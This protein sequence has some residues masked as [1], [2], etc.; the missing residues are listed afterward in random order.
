MFRAIARISRH[1]EAAAGEFIILTDQLHCWPVDPQKIPLIEAE[2]SYCIVHFEDRK[3][4]TVSRSLKEIEQLLSGH[5]FIRAN[6]GQIVNLRHI[7]VIQRPGMGRMIAKVKSHGEIE[8]SRRQ[9][10]AFRLKFAV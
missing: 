7:E 10:Q 8:F 3:P 5:S 2:G 6:R 1:R 4:L 9:A